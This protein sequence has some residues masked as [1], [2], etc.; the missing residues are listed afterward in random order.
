MTRLACLALL[1]TAAGC[2]D[3]PRNHDN[4]DG[5][6]GA[7][8][9]GAGGT[10]AEGGGGGTGGAGG[11]MGEPPVWQP[12]EHAFA[13]D[14]LAIW[15][16]SPEEFWTSIYIDTGAA[17]EQFVDQQRVALA[18]VDFAQMSLDLHGTSPTNAWGVGNG[19]VI[20][21]DGV[22]WARVDTPFTNSFRSVWVAGADDVWVVGGY[23]DGA[24]MHRQGDG[25]DYFSD[26]TSQTLFEG[27]QFGGLW[28]SDDGTLFAGGGQGLYVHDGNEWSRVP[29][30]DGPG[31]L[32]DELWG[33]SPTD[34]WMVGEMGT[35]RHYDGVSVER[36]T[37]PTTEH[38]RS[39]WGAAP[40]DIWA[41]GDKGALLHYDGVA[42][43]SLDIGIPPQVSG[44][45]AKL[46]VTSVWGFSA[47]DVWIVC[48]HGA[49]YHYAPP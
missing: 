41:V 47:S 42:W 44:G 45:S 36:V 4:D 43:E 13:N 34:V 11:A 40:D 21:Y 1:L 28:G 6:G 26:P 29:N 8:G 48:D 16:A 30:A 23:G 49:M 7:G 2:D 17:L 31:H 15:G 9:M 39:I 14:M 37:S 5:P 27:E 25:W 35:I 18:S 12:F 3:T 33:F 32:I 24:V 38:L 10:S 22:A 19:S 46:D 20:H